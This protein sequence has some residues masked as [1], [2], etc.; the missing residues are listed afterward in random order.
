MNFTRTSW[1]DED[2]NALVL[3]LQSQSD[4]KYKNFS[5]K[6]IPGTDNILGIRLPHLKIL[7]KQIVKGNMEEFLN[8]CKSDWHEEILLEG[9]VIGLSKV[10]I[11]N[12]LMII[13]GFVP[14]IKNWAVCDSFCSAL[15]ITVLNKQKMFEF[16]KTYIYSD[17]EFY[18]RFLIVMLLEY[19]IEDEY[20]DSVFEIFD[21]IKHDGYYVK[22]AVAWAISICFVKFETKTNKYLDECTLDDFTYNKALQ[23]IIES[24]R[25]DDYKKQTIRHKK[26]RI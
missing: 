6:L 8:V 5:K 19:F 2:Y 4:E 26:R 9:I 13:E 12:A 14:K 1:T 25:V 24:N 21:N 11:D 20:I 3:H 15:N 22:M 16:L 7:A 10:S 23:K 18:I 17:K